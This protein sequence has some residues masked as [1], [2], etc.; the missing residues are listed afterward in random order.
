MNTTFK[1]KLLLHLNQK[2]QESGEQGFTLIELLVVIIIIG[3]LAA[4]ALPSFLNQANKG[5]QAE[6]KQYISAINKSQQ[7]WYT[8]NGNF[9]TGTTANDWSSLG[10]G[11]K[12]QTANYTYA[13]GG[14][15]NVATAK[16]KPISAALKGYSGGVGLVG[17]QGADRTSQ[18]VIC[19]VTTAGTADPPAVTVAA[20][21]TEVACPSG[22][23]A[24]K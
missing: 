21:A 13:L 12:T 15:T 1:T 11:I 22:T 24:I 17:A 6:G 8:E 18:A 3:I 23:V 14:D 5:K 16:A 20:G 19:E 7:A 10:V 2:K 4:I 9:I